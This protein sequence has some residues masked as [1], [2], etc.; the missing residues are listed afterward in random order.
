[1][2]LFKGMQVALFRRICM[3]MNLTHAVIRAYKPSM[4]PKI[5]LNN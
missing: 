5:M 1:M 2:G 4:W 3:C